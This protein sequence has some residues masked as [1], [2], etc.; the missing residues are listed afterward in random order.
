MET[1]D[2]IVSIFGHRISGR[3]NQPCKYLHMNYSLCES[4]SPAYTPGRT[5]TKST[6]REET[7][8]ENPITRRQL[9]AI[10]VSLSALPVRGIAADDYPADN[11][12]FKPI[13]I[14]LPFSPGGPT[15]I[16]AR[17]LARQMADQMGV[18]VYV[19][20]LAGG[21]GVPGTSAGARAAP[22]GY[23]L[24]YAST[25]NFGVLPNLR[26][27]LPYDP[28]KSFM[29]IS[30]VSS[31]PFFVVVNSTLPVRNLKE[32]IDLAKSQPG[33]LN[34]A[35]PG[36]G[37]PHHLALELFKTTA[38]VDIAHVP[39]NGSGKV[40]ADLVAGRVQ[41]TFDNAIVLLPHIRSGK[42]RALAVA[43]PSR[44]QAIPEVPTAGEAGLKGFE[45][46]VWNGLLAP[47]KTPT[48]IVNRLN[49]EVQSASTSAAM[50]EGL[51]NLAMASA[52]SGSPADFAAFIES[53]L[54]R[55]NDIIKAANLV[56]AE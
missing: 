40:I 10:A 39:Y 16:M 50:R 22:D 25:T 17:T 32:L 43:S 1:I 44:Q 14:I 4:K 46:A 28:R 37:T 27:N 52:V 42:L 45:V 33:L 8:M 47:A 2:R 48:K 36:I 9:M 15:D 38:G 56:V 34:F 11:Y 5:T 3:L 35:S 24:T 7:S 6:W 23:T 18:P 21:S 49:K 53:E 13:K 54:K 29:P 31:G 41:L 19:E 51:S 20:N 26:K 55:W 30:Q 12:P